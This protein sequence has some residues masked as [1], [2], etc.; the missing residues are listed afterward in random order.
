M[1]TLRQAKNKI[2]VLHAFSG[3]LEMAQEAIG[4]GYFVSFGGP[5]TF[6]NNKQAPDL[7]RALPLEKVLIET[8]SPY[9]TP[10]PYRGK[11]NE[12]SYVKLVGQAIANLKGLS[13][14]EIATQT[15]KNARALFGRVGLQ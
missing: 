1:G 15:T 2:G 10:H 12:P 13:D 8:D 6:K 14:I 5:I 7:I 11:R 9:L 4:L 3:D